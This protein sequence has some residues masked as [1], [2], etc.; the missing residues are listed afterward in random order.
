MAR[1]HENMFEQL[2]QTVRRFEEQLLFLRE[3][4]EALRFESQALCRCLEKSQVVPTRELVAEVRRATSASRSAPSPLAR[5]AKR[6]DAPDKTRSTS[7]ESAPRTLEKTLARSSSVESIRSTRPHTPQRTR[8]PRMVRPGCLD[9]FDVMKPLLDK[10]TSGPE[11]RSA[12]QQVEQL[13]KSCDGPP[14]WSAPGTPLNAAVRSGRSDVS[15]LLLKARSD[16]N[17]SDSKG[18][19]PLHLAVFEGN[20][21][22]VRM[23]LMARADINLGDRHAQSALFFAP[24]RE[25]CKLLMEKRADSTLLNRHGQSALHLAGRAGLHDVFSWLALRMGKGIVEIQDAHGMTAKDYDQAHRASQRKARA[26]EGLE[27]EG[28][29]S[30]YTFSEVGD[31]GRQSELGSLRLRRLSED[32]T[33]DAEMF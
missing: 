32:L 23:L 13:L 14:T 3:D 27:S 31:E 33:E 28:D 22:I 1:E 8:P 26:A 7:P 11:Q 2:L 20:Q 9:L 16:A 15:R 29:S 17:E 10:N 6:A 19:A 12:L 4:H 5:V 30:T 18:V 25:I 24:T 21:D